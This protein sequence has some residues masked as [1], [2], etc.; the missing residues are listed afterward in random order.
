M[1]ILSGIQSSG[2]LHLGNYFGALKQFVSLQTSGE[3]LYFIADWHAL[4]SV[5]DGAAMRRNTLDVALDYLALGLDPARATMFVQSHVPAHAELA[6]ILSTVAPMALLERGHSY[7]DKLARGA[8]MNVG[9]FFYPVLMAADILLYGPQKVPV[10]Q[11]QKQHLEMARDIAVKFNTVYGVPDL[12]KQPEPMIL[13]D[14]AVVPGTDGQKMSKSYHNTL[15]L[16]APEAAL[17]KAIM[18]ITTDSTPVAE[19]K[20]SGHALLALLTLLA[21]TQTQQSI[22]NSWQAGGLGYGHYKKQLLGLFL[23]TFREAR[24]KR[25]ELVQNE[26]YARQ[27]LE[28]GRQKACAMAEQPW[29]SILNA[30]GCGRGT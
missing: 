15:D 7:K 27:V 8:P 10:G 2:K 16:F 19:P 17:K 5:H 18:G 20:P 6:W 13:A 26:D 22:V 1:R 3:A 23:D 9:L 11:D 21:D 30:V 25:A 4:T 14:T 12:L 28:D 29:R 24:L